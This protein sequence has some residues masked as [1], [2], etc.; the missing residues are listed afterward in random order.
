MSGI[1]ARAAW[2]C[3][4][5][6]VAGCPTLHRPYPVETVG[7]GEL[8]WAPIHVAGYTRGKMIMYDPA[9]I[10]CSVGYNRF[11]SELQQAIT[12]YFYPRSG[13]EAAQFAAEKDRVLEVH[14]GGKHVSDKRVDLVKDGQ[15]YSALVA[16]FEYEDTLNDARQLVSSQL[17]LIPL[18]TRLVKVRSTAPLAQAALAESGMLTLL[19]GV[20]WANLE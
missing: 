8:D 14:R 12:V 7:M 3:G 2:L 17:V 1:L 11:D 16:T 5:V 18:T 13:D 4:L 20:K 19:D 9:R 10:D 6:L 15:T